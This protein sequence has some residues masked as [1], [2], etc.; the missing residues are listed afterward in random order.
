MSRPW[1]A[2]ETG[3]LCESWGTVSVGAMSR[4]LNRTK[5]AIINKCRRLDLGAYLDSGDYITLNQL[6]I[7]VTGTNAAYSYKTISWVKNRELPIHTKTICSK[8]V[9]VVYLD[10][11]WKWAE[12][13]RSFLDFSKMEPL[14]LGEEP[15]WV[16]EQRRKD[17]QAFA[18]Q[19]KDPWTPDEESRL[20]ML[21]R[22]HKYGYAEL[23]EI[24]HRSAG[25]IQRKCTDLGIKERPVKA[26]NHS[27]ES[28]WMEADYE[29]LA[30]GIRQ[31]DSYTM[32]GRRIGKS[33]KA[34]RGKVY[35]VYLTE[36][37]DKVRAMMADGPWG[38][39]APMPTVKQGVH[40]SRC[41]Q[42]V[43]K[44]LSALVTILR[45]KMNEL[46]YEPFWQ[47]HMCVK[48]DD[49]LGCTAGCFDCDC[50]SEFQRIRPQ[51]C[52]RCG[53]TFLERK[54]NRMC[55]ECRA[56]KKKMAQR[57]WSVLNG[58]VRKGRI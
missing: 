30:D 1:T 43:K 4:R 31:G 23:S 47:R 12:K 15:A 37:A 6:V 34:I 46:G 7:A 25:A 16:A 49:V 11:F 56:A 5:G 17:Y 3:Y 19:R 26:D 39:G 9:R 40:L 48:W 58:T 55:S 27:K 22:Q 8:K 38:Y 50:C 10:E 41:R 14:A 42:A 51:Y 28:L 24:L 20:I 54:E 29:V 2:E 57:K 53:R 33:E 36:N 21:L 13:N 35:F 52:V 45:R 32:I 44:D 18:I